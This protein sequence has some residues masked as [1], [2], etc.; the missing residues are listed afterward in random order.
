MR[1]SVICF[2]ITV[3]SFCFSGCSNK[4]IPDSDKEELFQNNIRSYLSH[5]ATQ[6]TDNSLSGINSVAG[7]EKVRPLRY[8][9]FLEMM[10]IRDY[11]NKERTALN[12][13]ITGIIQQE[14]YRIEKLYYESLPGLYVPANLYIPDHIEHP[15]PA[16]LYVCGHSRTQKEYYQGYPQKFAQ[17]GFVCLIIETIQFGEVLGEH[18]GCYAN[19]WF[20]WYSRGYNPGG[21]E[22]WN[23]IRA[24]DLLTERPEVDKEN[25]GVTGGS[26]GG[27]QSWYLPAVDPRIKAAA[28]VCGASTLKAQVATR[29]I[30]WHCDCM[31]PIN[32][33]LW[34]FQDIGALIAPRPFLIVQADRDGYNQIG[35]VRQLHTDLDKIYRL[36]GKPE[37]NRLFEYPGKHG[38]QPSARKTIFSFFLEQLKGEHISP[39]DAGDMDQSPEH[40]LTGDELKAYTDGLPKG[41]LT[42]VIQDCFVKLADTPQIRDKNELFMYRDSVVTFLREKTFGAFPEKKTPLNPVV[43][44]QMLD[45]AGYGRDVYSFVPEEGWRLKLEIQWNFPKTEKRPMM[46]VL[47]SSGDVYEDSESFISGILEDGWNLAFLEARGVGESGWAESLQWHVRRASAWTGRT[48]ASMQVYDL[49]RGLEFCRTL[50]NVDGNKIGIAARDEM[51]VVAQYAALLGGKC[52]TLILKDPPGT[53]DVISRP[54]GKGIAT[55]MLNCLRVTDVNR[56]PALLP[57]TEISFIGEI[58]DAYQWS[59][60][61]REKLEFPHFDIIKNKER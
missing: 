61:I 58:P 45:G 51:G 34:D 14:G 50:E 10:G 27:A 4:N 41:D 38:T 3:I 5:A 18:H 8:Q 43:V 31:M 42:P 47:R 44:F 60:N 53:Q 1:K 48:I 29:S 35:S 37:N 13:K 15:C 20:N 22:L 54:D 56:L 9:Q 19:G 30:D 16:I 12:V 52:H 6:I 55:E 25:I 49:L 17:L 28:P 59:G 40:R 36:Y 32:N 26:G 39:E 2:A 33:Y 21:V 46:V 7:W 57:D 24:V 11:F 23:G